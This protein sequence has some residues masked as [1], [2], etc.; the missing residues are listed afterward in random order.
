MNYKYFGNVINI[1]E[2]LDLKVKLLNW[3]EIN[4]SRIYLESAENILKHW[5]EHWNINKNVSVLVD[6]VSQ[7][8]F[9]KSNWQLL[10]EVVM[11]FLKLSGL[12]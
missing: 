11:I 5:N 1:E 12:K 7:T 8:N 6:F 10:P 3:Q 9:E 4:V 2:L